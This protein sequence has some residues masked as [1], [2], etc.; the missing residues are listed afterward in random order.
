MGDSHVGVSLR[1]L[2][3]MTPN[4]SFIVT[5]SSL[6]LSAPEIA[7]PVYEVK[8]GGAAGGSWRTMGSEGMLYWPTGML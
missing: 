5:L 8:F 6:K 1:V 3:T 4:T 2:S 7:A